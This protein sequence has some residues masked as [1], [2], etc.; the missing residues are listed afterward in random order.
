MAVVSPSNIQAIAALGVRFVA[1]LVSAP[2][3]RRRR[4][5]EVEQA[6][7]AEGV[8]SVAPDERARA[9][10]TRGCTACGRCDHLAPGAVLPPSLLIPRLG[11]EAQD[12]P[13]ARDS[14]AVLREVA[15][16]VARVCPEGVDVKGVLWLIDRVG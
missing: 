8:R 3:R 16:D 7:A 2:F 11:R 15:D 1:R 4:R 14:L 13:L 10:L 9:A 5:Q 6:F 12:A